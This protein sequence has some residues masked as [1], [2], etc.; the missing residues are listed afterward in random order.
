[1]VDLPACVGK[2]CD[3]PWNLGI[4]TAQ[5]LWPEAKEP[6]L[7]PGNPWSPVRECSEKRLGWWDFMLEPLRKNEGKKAS[8]FAVKMF[9]Q[10]SPLI[11]Y[12]PM[13]TV[14]SWWI[15]HFHIVSFWLIIYIQLKKLVI[16]YSSIF[17]CWLSSIPTIETKLNFHSVQNPCWLIV[18]SESS[19][20]Q[21]RMITIYE[22][23]KLP[24][25]TNQF[26]M[27]A[28][29]KFRFLNNFRYLNWSYCTIFQARFQ[30]YIPTN[31]ALTYVYIY[32][33]W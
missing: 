26:L 19:T 30:R 24:F 28:M 12:I 31:T 21:L 29:R 18:E 22:L 6:P 5:S 3:K 13:F 10:K 4:F 25:L 9:P 33:I 15:P 14:F 11:A 7:V 16:A 27:N 2:W 1:M 17:F 32:I 8:H 20:I 23:G